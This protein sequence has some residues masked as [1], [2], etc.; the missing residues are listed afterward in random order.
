MATSAQYLLEAPDTGKKRKRERE[1]EER[2]RQRARENFVG[3]KH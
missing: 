3:T 1:R 2:E